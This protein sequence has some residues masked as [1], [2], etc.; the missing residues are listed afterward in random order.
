MISQSLTN[1]TSG[2]R[3][4]IELDN[5]DES[6]DADII[7]PCSNKMAD[8]ANNTVTTEKNVNDDES[9]SDVAD[10]DIIPLRCFANA[11][12]DSVT[13]EKNVI[14]NAPEEP[15]QSPNDNEV[16][17]FSLLIYALYINSMFNV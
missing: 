9:E 10:A 4:K 8:V 12:N 7:P 16:L 3:V 15:K 13:A 11:V 5:D 2:T 6:D 14:A 1:N 17:L